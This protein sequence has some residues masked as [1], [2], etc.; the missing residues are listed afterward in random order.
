MFLLFGA[1]AEHFLSFKNVKLQKY[2]KWSDT[3]ETKAND[4]IDSFKEKKDDIFLGIHVKNGI[5][6]VILTNLFYLKKIF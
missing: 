2:L 4:F 1:K 5:E 6:H 3:I